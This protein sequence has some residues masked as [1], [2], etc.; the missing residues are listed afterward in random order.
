[1]ALRAGISASDV[2]AIRRGDLPADKKL[3]ALSG[4]ARALIERKG[5][6]VGAEVDTLLAAGY[7]QSQVLDVIAGIAIST[8]AGITASMANTPVEDRFNPSAA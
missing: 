8:M 7:T 4:L 6:G 1:M 2:A 5:H 3:S